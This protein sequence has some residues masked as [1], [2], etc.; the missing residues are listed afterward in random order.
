VGIRLDGTTL[1]NATAQ[2]GRVFLIEDEPLIDG[3]RLPTG[4]IRLTAYARP[5]SLV[6]LLY[7]P[8]LGSQA[9]WQELQT[10]TV[11][12]TFQL[13]DWTPTNQPTA[14]FLIRRN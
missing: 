8:A 3:T 12:G 9:S 13:F 7:S 1:R 2:N 11:I 4:T 5:G 6:R 14:F 10:A